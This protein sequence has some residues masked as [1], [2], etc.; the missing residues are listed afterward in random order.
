VDDAWWGGA[1]FDDSAWTPV[2]G[3]PGGVGFERSV[4]YEDFISLDVGASM[5]G[6]QSSC[7]IRIPFNFTEKADPF[8]TMTLRI[9]YDD[10]FVA[11]LNGTEIARRNV[12]G[13]PAWNANAADQNPDLNAMDFEEI[14]ISGFEPLLRR[15]GDVLAIHGMNVSSTSSDLLISVELVA[16]TVEQSEQVST[17]ERYAG[18]ITLNGSTQVKARAQV[19]SKWS[20]L[21][22]ATF[23]VGPVAESLRISEIMYHPPETGSPDDPNLEYIELVNIDAESIDLNLVR[24]TDGVDFTFGSVVLAPGDRVLVVKDIDAFETRYGPGLPI[25][26]EYTGSLNNA[27][28]TVELRDAA[29]QIIQSFAFEDDW[30]GATDGNGF[31]LTVADLANT[32]P[33]A[34]GDK[35]TWR[36]SAAVGG[37]P[38]YDDAGI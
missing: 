37:S 32:D 20:A 16:T 27:G 26:G 28:E 12:M 6:R 34:W 33:Q 18:P 15:V 29:G 31:S 17:V 36:P 3:S 9:R 7:C 13:T 8:D 10:G 5:Y 19:G 25:A 21:N 4:G 14:E 1:T 30:Y 24:F 2:T 35:A 11:Y 38:G 22:E 23:A